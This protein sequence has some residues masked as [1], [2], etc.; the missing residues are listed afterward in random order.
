MSS[1]SRIRR[2]VVCVDGTF[3][4]PDGKEGKGTGNNTNVFR[5]FASVRYGK[6]T[7][8]NGNAVEQVWPPTNQDPN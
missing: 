6:F 5:I 7:D 8:A 3:Y 2:I 1:Q 4:N